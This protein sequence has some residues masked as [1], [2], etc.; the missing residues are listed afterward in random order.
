MDSIKAVCPTCETTY[1][2]TESQLNVAGGKVRCGKCM[3]IFQAKTTATK[4]Q[5]PPA[6]KPEPTKPPSKTTSLDDHGQPG[7]R[8]SFVNTDD[9][10]LLNN[11]GVRNSFN[12]KS[13]FETGEF[14]SLLDEV[15]EELITD[16]VTDHVD[17]IK[18][19]EE[20]RNHEAATNHKTTL[21]D[22]ESW[23]T[24]LLEE[25][26]DKIERLINQKSP[27]PKIEKTPFP[28]KEEPRKALGSSKD[29][30]DFADE[31]EGLD[32]GAPLTLSQDEQENFGL[33]EKEEMIERIPPEP[34]V[35]QY[36][37]RGSLVMKLAYGSAIA[38]C[39][40]LLG[41]QIAFFQ[42]DSLSREPEWHSF[43]QNFCGLF[44][45]T[46]PE[47]YNVDE[48]R[49]QVLTVKEHPHYRDA[50]IADIVIVNL[51]NIEQ[52]YPQLEL[53]FTDTSA[54]VVAARTFKPEEY[55]R[56]ELAGTQALMPSRQA[57]HI[58]LEIDDPGKSATGYTIALHYA[59]KTGETQAP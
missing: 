37:P 28:K 58:A 27:P 22:D 46:L 3:T 30:F 49:T 11:T 10:K 19:S 23:A 41:F 9:E 45:C 55:L 8:S 35:F 47:L 33:S 54:Q 5:T 40:F 7:H 15:N 43:Y 52:P 44:G 24:D 42:K 34:L 4:P 1:Q 29:D 56:G 18:I 38:L 51:A 57:V 2:L 17:E 59:E 36:L 13:E 48:I 12:K 6:P 21:S 32:L 20:L 25:E 16:H 26:D 50:L 31:L 53:M 39:L 14:D